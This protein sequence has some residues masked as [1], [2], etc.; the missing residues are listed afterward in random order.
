MKKILAACSIGITELKRSLSAALE[1]AGA[2]P[3]VV[4]NHNRR[5]RYIR[6][7]DRPASADFCA[8]SVC[9]CCCL[10]GRVVCLWSNWVRFGLPGEQGDF[11]KELICIINPIRPLL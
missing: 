9:V 2:E 5:V 6:V 8:A 11:S 7:A 10:R 3:V 1:Q 4:L